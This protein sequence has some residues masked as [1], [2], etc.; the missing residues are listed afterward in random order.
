MGHGGLGVSLRVLGS[1]G[2][3]LDNL[4]EAGTIQSG[5]VL[6][7]LL[8]L[9]CIAFMAVLWRRRERSGAVSLLVLIGGATIWSAAGAAELVFTNLDLVILACQIKY[10]GIL[11]IPS[12]WIAFSLQFAHTRRNLSRPSIL[13]LSAFPVFGT[14]V[15]FTNAWH[16]LVWTETW[17][18]W[19]GPLH[20]FG[21][22]RGPFYWAIVAHAYVLLCVG[23]VLLIRSVMHRHRLHRKQALLLLVM[24]LAPLS[25]NLVHQLRISPIPYLDL[26]PMAFTICALVLTWDFLRYGLLFSRYPVSKDQIIESMCEGV[27]LLDLEHRVLDLNTAAKRMLNAEGEDLRGLPIESALEIPT[28]LAALGSDSWDLV[29]LASDGEQHTYEVGV[30]PYRV[31]F[32]GVVG[33]VLVL[34]DVTERNRTQAALHEIDLRY[35]ALFNTMADAVL[36]FG[37][38]GKIEDANDAACSQLGYTREAL[39]QV[40]IW[41]VLSHTEDGIGTTLHTL[42]ERGHVRF[43]SEHVHRTGAHI[44][45]ELNLSM[46]EY[47]QT[48][49]VLSI[50]RDITMRK[51]AE[52]ELRQS[53][54]TRAAVFNQSSNGIVLTRLKSGQFVDVNTTMLQLIG[55]DRDSV[56]EKTA[57]DLGLWADRADMEAC[58]AALAA[59]GRVRDME[60][61]MRVADETIPCVLSAETVILNNL[62]FGLWEVRDN[63]EKKRA[64]EEQERLRVQLYEAQKMESVGRLAGGIAHDFNNIL[65]VILGYSEMLASELPKDSDARASVNEIATAGERARNLVRQLLAF[66]RKQ[67]LTIR[68]LDLNEIVTGFKP[69]LRRLIREDITVEFNLASEPVRTKADAGQLEHIL[70]NLCV[71]ASDAIDTAGTI[72]IETRSVRLDEALPK[73]NP[74]VKP[75]VYASLVVSDTGHGMDKDTLE[76]IF[77]PFFTTKETGKGTGL[78]L[79]TVFGIVKQHGGE[80]DVQS[81]P[82]RGTT[83]RIY[84]PEYADTDPP[85]RES[86]SMM[87]PR[88]TGQTI[89]VLEDEEAV[90]SML[91]RLL[92]RHGYRV[93]ASRT[94]DECLSL[95]E[96]MEHIDLLITD[97]VMTDMN[98]IEA[99]DRVAAMRPNVNTLFIS[100]YANEVIATLGAPGKRVDVLPKPFTAQAL[101]DKVEQLL[102]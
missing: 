1:G 5:A 57:S 14:A 65:A 31:R 70:L 39:Q 72:R 12:A 49:H 21:A 85:A 84:L 83:F 15:T 22:V 100:A 28:D 23:T 43:E 66:G 79:A 81:H 91:C 16:G 36:V 35:R 74:R 98:S 38:N 75:G 58:E 13:A 71:N 20:M 44:P 9:F 52:N 73:A 40:S 24:I 45:V 88:G 69:M 64:E 6:L 60:V 93:A 76:Q 41:N 63:R 80:I 59:E 48:W 50:A 67:V 33:Y 95:A 102:R 94:V 56:L 2:R 18:A 7:V 4:I 8:S 26:T 55:R 37:L 77:D 27:V 86:K 89:L 53:E 68:V 47:G 87:R 11:I 97:A 61:G 90:R 10:L 17:I 92:T 19:Q 32:A 3:G 51:K 96:S 29:R 62:T 99:R 30:S 101:C 82:G 46:V 54:E 25:F 34:R 42:E 78:G